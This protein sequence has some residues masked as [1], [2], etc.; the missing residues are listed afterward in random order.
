MTMSAPRRWRLLIAT[1]ALALCGAAPVGRSVLPNHSTHTSVGNVN[2]ASS[3]CH[4]SV[5]PWQDSN[6]LHNE[7][8]T[9]TRL[10]R[11]ATAYTTLLSP[12]SQRIA[13]ALG[14][15]E[16]AHEAAVCL[17]CHAHAPAISRRGERFVL[18]D[19]VGC[20]ACH[21][22][23]GK[24]LAS[25]TAPDASHAGNLANG[26]YPTSD[27]LAQATLCASCHVGDDS[28]WV[29][30]RIM[31]AG[32]PRLGFE[33]GTFAALQPAHYR[34]DADWQSRKGRLDPV[35]VWALG[36]W[37]AARNLLQRLADPVKGRDGLFPELS[38]FDCHACHHPMEDQ[39]WTPR[40]GAGPGAI[41]VNDG[42]L[43]M[44][45]A[46]VSVIAP[47]EAA[48]FRADV[49]RLHAAVSAGQGDPAA[50]IE[51]VLRRLASVQ[52]PL[53]DAN[54]G[55]AELKRLVLV[56]ADEAGQYTDYAG[57]EQAW[58]LLAGLL[59]ELTET[60]RLPSTPALAEALA[61]AR[62][63]LRSE[64]AF[65]AG[66]FKSAVL[67]VAAIVRAAPGEG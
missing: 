18:A 64:S 41:R 50:A 20:E 59:D 27:P 15:R 66:P 29:T 28:R 40:T 55:D 38:V 44:L 12:R 39:R 33:I 34:L 53:A 58:M 57:A 45:Q 10:D 61:A 23:A 56:L 60:G 9:W 42:H 6:I 46:L 13:G 8:T 11:H 25:H 67:R 51:Q 30:H 24:W 54:Y 48:G 3:T 1:V 5:L 21:G 19:G 4:G 49:R 52:G 43:L 37:V 65:R 26:L 36:Q 2:C 31:G 14:L 62:H 32:H 35:Q 17:D 16:P 22:P 47:A 63:T 7:Y